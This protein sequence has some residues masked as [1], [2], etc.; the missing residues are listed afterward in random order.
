MAI[1][2]LCEIDN[3]TYSVALSE[4]A[5]AQ[6]EEF[7]RVKLGDTEAQAFARS[8]N[9]HVVLIVADVLI[10]VGSEVGPLALL[11]PCFVMWAGGVVE[12]C[13]LGV[14]FADYCK[15]TGACM[16]G[17]ISYMV[18]MSVENGLGYV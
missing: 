3:V 8:K 10:G 18:S 1:L 7:G 14:D 16:L 5:R 9:V 12:K 13:S 11:S 17:L 15:V 6:V 4:G 2:F